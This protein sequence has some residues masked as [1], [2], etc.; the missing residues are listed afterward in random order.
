MK[1]P[2]KR[3][4]FNF[5]R[6]YFDILNELP[7]NQDKLD[8]LLAVINKQFLDE[9]PISLTFPAKLAY[10]GQ[11]HQI[12]QSVK[13]YKDKMK[14]NLKGDPI[15]G[16]A[17]GG[18]QGPIQPPCQ[19]EKEKEEEKEKVQR[20]IED[21]KNDFW[22]NL[23][24]SFIDQYEVN[25]LKDFFE[26]WTEASPR[27]RKMRFEKEKAFDVSRRLK[28]WVRNQQRFGRTKTNQIDELK[29]F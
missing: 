8:F 1:K 22:Q 4:A 16:G 24:S 23:S 13:G 27:A 20:S 25:L 29:D 28:T 17:K 11:R 26:Y 14:T 6:S 3:K 10:E 21:R 7:E 9:E 12:E 15:E 5:L 18:K 19:Q 2:T